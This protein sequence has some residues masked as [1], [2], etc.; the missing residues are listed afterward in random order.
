MSTLTNYY[1]KQQGKLLKNHRKMMKI[2]E[3][4]LKQKYGTQLA[5]TTVSQSTTEF[6]NLI[7]QIPYIGGSANSMT[8]TLIQMSSLLALYRVLKQHGKRVDE[9]GELLYEI[10]QAQVN[11]FPQWLRHLIGKYYLSNWNQKR[12]QKKAAV[13]QKRQYPGDFVIEVVSGNQKPFT[14][15]VNYLEC[16]IV[17]FFAQQ[18][19]AEL[20]PFMCRI[21]YLLFPAMGIQLRRTGT[22][23]QGCTHCDFRFHKE[24]TP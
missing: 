1:T 17:K 10:A 12:M 22:I 3:P 16:G 21:D 4:I 5:Q 8:D 20:T 9:I 23:A 7:P 18:G 14:W 6:E 13:S 15:G 24:G 11:R 19:A 2:G